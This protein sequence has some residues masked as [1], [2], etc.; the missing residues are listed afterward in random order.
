MTS[1]LP[2]IS[3][4]MIL[5][6]DGLKPEIVDVGTNLCL[7]KNLKGLQDKLVNVNQQEFKQGKV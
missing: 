3:L 5:F 1:N 2:A 4:G 6:G 7:W